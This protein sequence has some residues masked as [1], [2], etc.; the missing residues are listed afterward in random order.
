MLVG[1]AAKILP[2]V[3]AQPRGCPEQPVH[4]TFG[5]GLASPKLVAPQPAIGFRRRRCGHVRRARAGQQPGAVRRRGAARDRAPRQSAGRSGRHALHQPAHHRAAVRHRLW[6]RRVNLRGR[7]GGVEPR[8]RDRLVAP[9][10]VDAGLFRLGAVPWQAARR[11]ISHT[12]R[13]TCDCRLHTRPARLARSCSLRLAQTQ[14]GAIE[15]REEGN[16]KTSKSLAYLV[17]AIGMLGSLANA[18]VLVHP[19]YVK[20]LPDQAI[21]VKAKT[22]SI[23]P[24]GDFEKGDLFRVDVNVLND[25]YKDLSVYVVDAANMALVRQGVPFSGQGQTRKVA[26]FR[27]DAKA[28]VP[29]PHFLVFDNRYANIIDKKVV[30]RVQLAVRLSEEKVQAMKADLGLAYSGLKRMFQFK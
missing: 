23:F 18:E 9:E 27:I 20:K 21:V 14:V 26:P 2:K 22:F 6:N 25:V 8:A 11:R 28:T 19:I 24:L 1:H 3:P 17:F 5:H 15:K 13:G 10:R 12:R 29:G 7:R 16:M 4:R 30:F